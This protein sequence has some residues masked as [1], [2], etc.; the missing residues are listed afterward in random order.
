[1]QYLTW[2]YIILIYAFLPLYM[3]YGYFELGEYKSL[4]YLWISGAAAIIMLIAATVRGDVK[5][6]ITKDRADIRRYAVLGF[7][8]TN[9]LTWLFSID[10]KVAFL[11]LSGWRTGFL[12]ILLMVFFL[13]YFS[14][15]V[16]P[17]GL[18]LAAM[19]VTALLEFVLGILGRFEVHPI[20]IFGQDTSFL[21]TIGNINW[22][23]GYLSIFVP[24]G[25]GFTVMQKKYS[26]G[27]FLGVAYTFPGLMALLTQ[28]SDSAALI[29]AGTYGALLLFG[30][31]DRESFRRFL[32]QFAILGITMELTGILTRLLDEWYALNDSLMTVICNRHVGLIIIAAALLFYRLSRL[33]EEISMPWKEKTYEIAAVTV[34]L[35]AVIAGAVFFVKSFDYSFGNNRGLI[36]SMSLDIFKSMSPWQKLVGVGQD[37]FY[38]FAYTD[39]VMADSLLNIFEG[40]QLTNAHCEVLTILVE[41]GLLGVIS[42]LFLFGVALRHFWQNKR[43]RSILLFALPV[44]AYFCNGLV[45]F[46]QV[47]STPYFFMMLGMGMSLSNS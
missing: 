22:Y 26:R 11:G 13:L 30:L 18:L 43:E 33:F 16:K 19:L 9:L 2:A 20:E 5:R 40:G 32:M 36:W 24:I 47:M 28:G 41:R 25:I 8:F 29:L 21:A 10:K 42:Y 23:A 12:T 15:Y 3:R 6:A 14:K 34:L 39:P 35:A 44:I 4:A 38:D 1:M 27:F 31:K 37:C 46:S 7:L 45:S 17:Q